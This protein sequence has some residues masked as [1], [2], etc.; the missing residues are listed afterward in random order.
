MGCSF[1][2]GVSVLA[3]GCD[4]IS[5]KKHG[6]VDMLPEEGLFQIQNVLLASGIHARRAAVVQRHLDEPSALGSGALTKKHRA[7]QHEIEAQQPLQQ[8]LMPTFNDQTHLLE[9]PCTSNLPKMWLW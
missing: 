8:R 2:V 4:S 1:A 3:P 9:G 6:S 7:L 5:S